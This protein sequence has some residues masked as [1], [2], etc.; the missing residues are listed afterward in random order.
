LHRSSQKAERVVRKRLADGTVKEYRYPA[1]A[2]K[3]QRYG[4]D[5]IGALIMA[6]KCSPEWVRLADATQKTMLVYIRELERLGTISAASITRRDML[7]IRDAIASTRGHGAATGFVR[8]AS[9]VWGWAVDREWIEHS[10]MERVKTLPNSALPTWTPEDAATAIRR[11]PE[12]LRR[13]VV[14]AFHTGQRRGDLVRLTWGDYDGA[15]IRLRQQKTGKALVLPVSAELR[16][17][18]DAWPRTAVTILTDQNGNSWQP[19]RLTERL[20][21]ALGKICLPDHLGIHGLRKL[22]ATMLAQAGC[23]PHEIAAWTGHKTL[24]MVAHY[25]EAV[26]QE[27]LA[28]AAVTRLQPVA[29][30]PDNRKIRR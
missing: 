26:D 13:A 1:H 29:A 8:A 9:V 6:Y 10:P 23:S 15:T 11:L 7:E 24:A 21:H 3:A 5:S 28:S 18:I 19:Q 25:T 4:A 16:A 12:H 27:R 22:R 14:L 20:R 17:E 30:K 2:P